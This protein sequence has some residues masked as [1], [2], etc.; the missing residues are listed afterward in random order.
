MLVCGYAIEVDADGEDEAAQGLKLSIH[1]DTLDAP[2]LL[3]R[4]GHWRFRIKYTIL[5]LKIW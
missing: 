2:S 4:I 1:Q 3:R 5:V